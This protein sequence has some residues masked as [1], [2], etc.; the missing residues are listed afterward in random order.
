MQD[1]DFAQILPIFAQILGVSLSKCWESFLKF[2]RMCPNFAQNC[3]KKFARVCGRIPNS[4]ST[5]N[6]YFCSIRFLNIQ[7]AE[8]DL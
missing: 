7:E 2:T 6:I 8:N 3:P 4:Y 5:D 1:F